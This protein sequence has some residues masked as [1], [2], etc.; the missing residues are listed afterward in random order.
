MMSLAELV[1][2]LEDNLDRDRPIAIYD[3]GDEDDAEAFCISPDRRYRIN[4]EGYKLE[5]WCYWWQGVRLTVLPDDGGEVLCGGAVVDALKTRMEEL[6]CTSPNREVILTL[7]DDNGQ[8]RD[9]EISDSPRCRV[10]Y[11]GD[12]V[13]NLSYSKRG[14]FFAKVGRALGAA[15]VVG[16]GGA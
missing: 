16:G 7:Y 12:N 8:P 9:Y 10:E 2:F 1:Q 15:G 3:M 6:Y 4:A 5:E 14:H 11:A 13:I